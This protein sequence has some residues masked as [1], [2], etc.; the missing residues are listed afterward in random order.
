M[1]KSA[2]LLITVLLLTFLSLNAPAQQLEDE[3][4]RRLEVL[5]YGIETQVIELIANLGTENDK[6]FSKELLTVFDSSTSPKLRSSILDYY[7]RLELDLAVS[8][9]V[10]IIGARDETTDALVGSAFSYLLN[11][12]SEAATVYARR[13]IEDEERKY[14]IAAIKI[15]GVAGNDD[16]VSILNKLFE[17]STADA[18][19]KQEI[20]LSFGKMRA[21]T[22]F[23][24]LST[25]ASADD[26]GKIERMYASTALGDL[27][28]PRAIPV[29][30]SAS[31]S[32]DPNVRASA[33]SALQNFNGTKADNA[34]LQGLRD[35]HVIPRLAAVKA[36]GKKQLAEARPFLEF[37]IKTDPERSIKDEAIDVLASLGIDEGLEFLVNYLEDTKS[38][39]AHRAKSF[40]AILHHG[41]V[42]FQEQ[43]MVVLRSAAADKDKSL[44]TALAKAS[45]GSNLVQ[46]APVA[47]FLLGND[48]H[49]IRLGA[50]GWAERNKVAE[51][52]PELAAMSESDPVESLRK[53]ISA[54]I[55][56]IKQP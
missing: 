3:Y 50:V 41:G 51:L 29:L 18:G 9:A 47:R 53:R 56:R 21:V 14:L 28:D 34:I 38:P 32:S 10:D 40:M 19:I 45:M 20:L 2:T 4:Q 46:A 30:I 35:Q 6:N 55:D 36:V 23:E 7:S 25:I 27:G 43:A 44:F 31:A 8:Q 24:L 48:D 49:L 42:K 33:I 17:S 13:I 54:A 5:H 12:K 11:L 37:R 39:V 1:K 26:S 15:L 52:L 22:S 16:D